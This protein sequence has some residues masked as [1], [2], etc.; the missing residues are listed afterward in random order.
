MGRTDE[1][2]QP[3]L[4]LGDSTRRSRRQTECA[5][6]CRRRLELLPR[7]ALLLWVFT[8]YVDRAFSG[9]LLP[10]VGLIFL[11]L[12]LDIMSYSSSGY[13]QRQRSS[14]SAS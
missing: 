3:L 2:M 7:I 11:G 5:R 13:G 14:A 8:S 9:F 4:P 6:R 10:L 12:L 1:S